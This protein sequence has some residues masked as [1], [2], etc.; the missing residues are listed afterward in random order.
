MSRSH[1]NEKDKKH[2]FAWLD[3]LKARNEPIDK[4]SL[5]SHYKPVLLAWSQDKSRSQARKDYIRDHPAISALFSKWVKEDPGSVLRVILLVRSQ[6]L[7]ALLVEYQRRAQPRQGRARA[8]AQTASGRYEAKGEEEAKG[9]SAA[10]AR[11]MTRGQLHKK[12]ILNIFNRKAVDGLIAR[13]ASSRE[14]EL[15][16]Q[17]KRCVELSGKGEE[18]YSGQYR[19]ADLQHYRVSVF[20][21]IKR[22]LSDNLNSLQGRLDR[23][24]AVNFDGWSLYWRMIRKKA[25][26]VTNCQVSGDAY[27]T[28]QHLEMRGGRIADS[29]LYVCPV[30]KSDRYELSGLKLLGVN[31]VSN[32][33]INLM[34]PDGCGD[35]KVK[36]SHFTKTRWSG[37]VVHRIADAGD[38]D[39]MPGIYACTFAES[40]QERGARWDHLRLKGNEFV[41]TVL[42]GKLTRS[43]VIG[44]RFSEE[45]Q[46]S[47]VFDRTQ[48][49]GVRF[50][51]NSQLNG[52]FDRNQFLEAS[53]SNCGLT[54]HFNQVQFRGCLFNKVTFSNTNIIGCTFKN[55]TL[56]NCA[57]PFMLVS[58]NRWG[59]V[60][61]QGCDMTS[62]FVGYHD[63]AALVTLNQSMHGCYVTEKEALLRMVLSGVRLERL[64]WGRPEMAAFD[65]QKWLAFEKRYR[66]SYPEVLAEPIRMIS[67]VMEPGWQLKDLAEVLS[68]HRGKCCFITT[69]TAVSRFGEALRADC[70]TIDLERQH[71]A[72]PGAV[73][74]RV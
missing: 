42:A 24:K 65:Q 9:H 43:T 74:G 1:I 51:T 45:S 21:A 6:S 70:V 61:F 63:M 23:C 17:V 30:V 22:F 38:P 49:R 18:F 11:P 66:E 57:V 69:R 28:A 3:Q 47:G 50:D 68:L 59:D 31:E 44:G 64:D 29:H 5:K 67:R 41:N 27:L 19:F 39:E 54:G 71:V 26:V 62:C 32:T 60:R 14:R 35:F 52:K 33:S 15:Y 7:D 40:Q 58:Q 25:L 37:D 72:E 20:K 2:F 56:T 46:L 13:V 53:F 48:F 10:N 4:A 55:S 34:L 12:I 16:Q 73:P 36:H 8:P